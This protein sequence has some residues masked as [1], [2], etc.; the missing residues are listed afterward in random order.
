MGYSI[1]QYTVKVGAL[2]YLVCASWTQV[3]YIVQ[4]HHNKA[5]LAMHMGLLEIEH[6]Q[7]KVPHHSSLL[8]IHH[9]VSVNSLPMV[10]ARED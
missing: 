10:Y 7:H 8:T 4:V 1:K 3:G 6:S 5:E 9:L 2:T